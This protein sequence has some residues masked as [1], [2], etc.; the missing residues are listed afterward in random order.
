MRKF[1]DIDRCFNRRCFGLGNHFGFNRRIDLGDRFLSV[2]DHVC[3]GLCFIHLGGDSI[4]SGLQIFLHR[5][6]ILIRTRRI[7]GQRLLRHC[8]GVRQ[9]RGGII[10][11]LG[12]GG[13]GHEGDDSAA[14]K[15]VFHDWLLERRAGLL[16]S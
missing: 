6:G 14:C 16:K 10:R 13:R 7:F 1:G 5:H 4:I 11:G 9:W 12:E 2:A 8:F 3:R 15:Q